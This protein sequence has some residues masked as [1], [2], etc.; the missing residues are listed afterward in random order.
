MRIVKESF[1]RHK[2]RPI[3]VPEG[4]ISVIRI[5]TFYKKG[6]TSSPVFLTWKWIFK[7]GQ[8]CMAWKAEPSVRRKAMEIL[9]FFHLSCFKIMWWGRMPYTKTLKSYWIGSHL[10]EIFGEDKQ[11]F[12][13][14][15]IKPAP[16]IC[17]LWE[18]FQTEHPKHYYRVAENFF[19][20]LNSFFLHE[21]TANWN[22]CE[23]T[24]G[25]SLI[26]RILASSKSQ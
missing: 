1:K 23:L 8:T 4:F 24:L 20:N 18:G 21:R 6:L 16:P 5:S 22:Y 11:N 13:R 15:I 2:E 19:W 25:V 26:R 9:K 12:Q 7:R 3:P 17:S 14:Q 10:F